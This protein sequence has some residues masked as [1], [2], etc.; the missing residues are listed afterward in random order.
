VLPAAAR[1]WRGGARKKTAPP[2]DSNCNQ[3]CKLSFFNFSLSSS[4]RLSG[5]RR[6][7]DHERPGATRAAAAPPSETENCRDRFTHD[8]QVKG[9]QHK[10]EKTPQLCN[11]SKSKT[12]LCNSDQAQR[13]AARRQRALFGRKYTQTAAAGEKR[14]VT[15]VN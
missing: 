1:T 2:L 7:R 14:K 4:Q 13:S 6:E 15:E 5:G 3:S 10:K 8:N 11:Q 12:T 9:A